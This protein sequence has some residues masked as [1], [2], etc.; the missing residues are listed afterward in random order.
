MLVAFQKALSSHVL[1]GLVFIL[2]LLIGQ[3]HIMPLSRCSPV[4]PGRVNKPE[5]YNTKQLQLVS[6]LTWINVQE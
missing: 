6:Q 1:C 3:T 4:T 5:G 2:V